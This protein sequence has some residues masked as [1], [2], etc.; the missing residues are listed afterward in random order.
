MLHYLLITGVAAAGLAAVVFVFKYLALRDKLPKEAARKGLHT[1][2]A[3]LIAA[4]PVFIPDFLIL[5]TLGMALVVV[6][7]VAVQSEFFRPLESA[8][9]K[10]W[11]IVYFPVTFS[12]M[13][14][15][16]FETYWV[17][18][19]SFIIMGLADSAA[20]LVG[21]RFGKHHFRITADAKSL[22]GSS[23]FFITTLLILFSA[24]TEI[25]AGTL[26]QSEP[27]EITGAFVLA[28]VLISLM[29]TVFEAVSSYGADNL[30]VTIAASVLLFT[31]FSGSEEMLLQFGT[32]VL[33][34]A[35]MAVVSWKARLLTTSGSVGL[36]LLASFIYGFG[37]WQWTI[38]ILVFFLLSSA[39]SKL[40]KRVNPSVEE[41]MGKG[42]RR[43]VTQV[44]ANG[45][46]G[47]VLVCCNVLFPDPLWFVI[48]LGGLAAVTADTWATETGTF[49]SARTY[50]IVSFQRIEQGLS[51]G[52]SLPGTLGAAAGAMVIALTAM[53]WIS[54]NSVIFAIA[55]AGFIG[56]T[57]DSILGA[58]LQGRYECSV[59]GLHTEKAE[60]CGAPVT[61]TGGNEWLNNDMVNILC[62]A[63]GIL[64]TTIYFLFVI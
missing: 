37:G 45:G 35:A 54:N 56:S 9:R 29:L 39:L 63:T 52:V 51:G 4:A 30:T 64:I 16:W 25:V 18:A 59:C 12:F 43:D 44:L 42:D 15:L 40:R 58:S 22:L 28:V 26:L 61:R 23:A 60:H 47:A 62:A 36:F 19:L 38:P 48:Y 41:R 6:L 20:A 27:F 55:F 57:V 24:S 33:L 17:F 3:L 10:S 46:F 5:F 7:F 13:L 8:E 31:L 2:T 11:G 53:F 32:G 34:G 1:L 50:N 49:F 14:L 21:A